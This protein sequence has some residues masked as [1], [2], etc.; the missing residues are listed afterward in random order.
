M[1]RRLIVIGFA[2]WAIGFRADPEPAV[3]AQDDRLPT[4]RL[5]P[6]PR[7]VMPGAVDSN[8]PMEWDLVDGTP[9]LFAMA[10]WGGTPAL[11]AGPGLDR[12]QRVDEVTFRPHPGNGIWIESL[13]VD[14]QGTWY[15]YYHHE[16]PA[17][18]CGVGDR[19]IPRIGAAR[20]VDRGLTW[21]DLG[22]ILDA[23]PGSNA[24]ASTNR[25][26]LG[27]VGDLSAL[28]DPERED[29]ILFFSMYSK[30]PAAQGVAVARLAWADR[31]APRGRVMVWQDDVW[32]P[33]RRIAGPAELPETWEYPS[34]TPLVPV[35]K[36]WHD[37]DAAADAFWGPSVHWNTHLERYVMLLNRTK[38]ESFNNEGIYVS[39]ARTL[40]NP[41]EWTAPHKI[42]SG[43]GW[44]P[45]VA[46]LEAGTGT[47]KLA[48]ARARFFT[49]GRSEYW[50]DFRW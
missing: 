4:T 2:L 32:L 22:I 20:S 12:L 16:V 7:L 33:A 11:L 37:G 30:H 1:I 8:I 41:R 15:G 10:S 39:Y 44:Y 3:H 43:G 45:Q 13:I 27:G 38:D 29:L 28:L 50:I 40:E 34:G 31:D 46:G 17:D 21:E 23:P 6:A 36:P 49:T 35:S 42:M 19:A 25:F 18:A 24:C 9:R 14:D 48:G 26:V 5:V 47:D